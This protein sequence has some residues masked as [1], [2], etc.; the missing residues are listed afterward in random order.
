MS[1]QRSR[2][3]GFEFRK[4]AKDKLDKQNLV[5]ASTPKLENYFRKN[6]NASNSTESLIDANEKGKNLL[7]K[8]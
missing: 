6:C 1:Y 5:I 4:Q 3:S 8:I 7:R 2:L